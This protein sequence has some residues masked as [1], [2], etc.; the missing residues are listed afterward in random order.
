[1]T[2]AHDI[3]LRD[4]KKDTSTVKE[5]LMITTSALVRDILRDRESGQRVVRTGFHVC[6]TEFVDAIIT[7]FSP[8]LSSAHIN[9]AIMDMCA[10]HLCEAAEFWQTTC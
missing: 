2:V 1:M 9:S 5:E 3:R 10:L 7:T 8:S 4:N 6:A